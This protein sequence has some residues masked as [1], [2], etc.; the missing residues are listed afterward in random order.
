MATDFPK[1]KAL[2]KNLVPLDALSDGQLDQLI[3]HISVERA[4]NEEVLFREGDEEQK[5]VYLLQGQIQ[6]LSGT[7]EVELVKSGTQPARF[8]LAHQ[9]PRKFSGRAVGDVYFVRIESRIIHSLVVRNTQSKSEKESDADADW[10]TLALGAR[11]LQQVPP[12]NIQNVLRRMEEVAVKASETVIRQGEPGEYFYILA[13]GTAVVT[14]TDP[15]GERQLAVLAP[16]DG[17]GEDALISGE[18]RAASITM[19][20]NGRLIRLPKDDFLELI[21]RP[22]V[23]G[24]RKS[25]V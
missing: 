4:S 3:K 2:F 14:R 19:A 17:F 18:A 8:A 9:W 22:L 21:R 5:H 1:N 16:G 25:V 11:V 7:R 12:A 6:L 23:Q 24:D 15:G 10:M 20:S 13:K